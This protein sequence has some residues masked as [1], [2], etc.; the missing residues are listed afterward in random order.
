MTM[1]D[2][3]HS[4]LIRYLNDVIAMERDIVNAVRTQMQDDRVEA[5]PLLKDLFMDLAVHADH[6]TDMFESLVEEEGGSLGGAVKEGIAAVTGVVSGLTKMTR[7]HPLSRMV[8]DNTISMNVATV[9]YSMLLTLAMALQHKRCEEL[10]ASALSDCP[11]FVL[12]LNDL[13]PHVVV[14]ELS[15]D[16]PVPNAMAAPQALAIT[17]EVWNRLEH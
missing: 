10:A 11:K 17:R 13:I 14:E 8:R 5:H 4:S 9:S 16:A 2:T 12:Q 6:R 3:H 7:Q 1:N 15:D